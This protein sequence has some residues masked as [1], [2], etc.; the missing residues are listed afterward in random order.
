M[1]RTDTRAAEEAALAWSELHQASGLLAADLSR[2]LESEA[3]MTAAEHDILWFLANTPDRRLIMSALADRLLL[4]RSGATR[5]VDRMVERG[6]VTREVDPDN[7]RLT[8]AVLAPG[9]IAAVRRSA[10]VVWKVRPALFDDR[11]TATDVAD[12]RRILGKLLRRLDVVS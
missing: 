7:R 1:R 10:H 11:L 8:Y 4:S 2:R 5:L 3:D 9:G 12:L 6:W